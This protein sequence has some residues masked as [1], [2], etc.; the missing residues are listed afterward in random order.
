MRGCS[1]AKAPRMNGQFT[2]FTTDTLLDFLG[3]LDRKVMIEVSRRSE[4][5][6]YQQVTL[7]PQV[8]SQI[9]ESR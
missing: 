5:Q 8:S 7:A 9:P 1:S 6:P 2:R 3:R 4:G